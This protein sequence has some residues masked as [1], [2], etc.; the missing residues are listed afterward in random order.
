MRIPDLDRYLMELLV[1]GRKPPEL[2]KVAADLIAG[3][4]QSS[5]SVNLWTRWRGLGVGERLVG[6]F[7]ARLRSHGPVF[8]SPVPPSSPQFPFFFFGERPGVRC[9]VARCVQVLLMPNSRATA[10]DRCIARSWSPRTPSGRS[11]PPTAW[12][13]CSTWCCSRW[14]RCF[15]IK[16]SYAAYLCLYLAS[17]CN[18]NR[19]HF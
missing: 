2:S 8:C 14:R 6:W 5:I 10:G 15:L 1:D 11:S 3:L 16:T 19:R 13:P 9:D 17:F 18:K 12:M 7:K 4:L